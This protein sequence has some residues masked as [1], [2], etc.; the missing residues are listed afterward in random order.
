MH[1]LVE[2][3]D[4]LLSVLNPAAAAENAQAAAAA[5][6]E[7]GRRPVFV[8]CN[9]IALQTMRDINSII[10]AAGAE[11]I[12]AGIIGPP[13][14]GK[15]SMRLYASGPQAGLAMQLANPRVIVRLVNDR[16]GD[17]SSV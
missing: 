9:A 8:D 5:M 1:S 16:I 15:A 3:C 13:P 2:N 17:A 11:C 4:M 10:H 12:D 14:C 7:T 6:R